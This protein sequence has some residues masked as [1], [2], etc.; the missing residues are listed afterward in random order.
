MNPPSNRPISFSVLLAYLTAGLFLAP[1]PVYCSTTDQ[2]CGESI[3]LQECGSVDT[4]NVWSTPASRCCQNTQGETS[5]TDVTIQNPTIKS[6]NRKLTSPDETTDKWLDQVPNR[7]SSIKN[8]RHIESTY[9]NPDSGSSRL[10]E[11]RSVV[12][13][14]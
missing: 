7:W 11:I 10:K 5:C 6:G 8:S 4:Q 14:R 2:Y 1:S 3:G 12:L 13:I 9:A